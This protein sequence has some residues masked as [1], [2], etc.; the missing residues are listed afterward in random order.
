MAVWQQVHL[1]RLERLRTVR[2]GGSTL[3]ASSPITKSKM[4]AFI[5]S[6]LQMRKGRTDKAVTP[7]DP[8]VCRL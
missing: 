5:N 4:I 1:C 6:I 7:A 8:T 3:R 2:R